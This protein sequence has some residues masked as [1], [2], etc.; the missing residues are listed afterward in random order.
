M[1]T[2]SSW[3][4][5]SLLSALFAALTAV[6]AKAGLRGVDPDLATLLRT[7]V[8]AV[9]LVPFVWVTGKWVN[10]ASL[11]GKSLLFIVLSAVATGLSWVCYFRALQ[12]GDAS[13]VAPVDKL[14]IALVVGMAF[15]FLGER[16]V[17]K[18]WVGVVL[19]T[20]GVL[21]LALRR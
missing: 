16:P 13:K 5:W 21:L 3:L 9:M 1:A 2:T 6:L 12:I 17:A 7:M 11:S 8:I 4:T 10:P 14:S 20:T 18:D 19:I 15:V